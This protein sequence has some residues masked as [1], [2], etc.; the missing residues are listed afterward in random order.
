MAVVKKKAG[1]NTELATKP[2]RP[3]KEETLENWYHVASL[4]VLR[5]MSQRK[6]YAQVYGS[7]AT[8]NVALLFKNPRFLAI[9][10]RL[11]LSMALDE[12]AVK[13]NIESLYLQTITDPGEQVKN[14]LA[15]AQQWQKLRG[16]EC[17]KVEVRSEV[18]DIILEQ[19]R[20]CE[21]AME[22]QAEMRAVRGRTLR[23]VVDAEEVT[24][25]EIE[26]KIDDLEKNTI[27]GFD[28]F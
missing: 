14:K 8:G 6:A 4:H 24:S 2:G 15:A 28:V 11:R 1:K 22:E 3:V 17:Q 12:E 9:V 19:L 16:L 23:H 21:K 25:M 10:N 26:E 5:G 13:R 20:R 27:D 7:T 18:D